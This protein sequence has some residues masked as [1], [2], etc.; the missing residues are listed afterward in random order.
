MHRF[1]LLGLTTFAAYATIIALGTGCESPECSMGQVEACP[2]GTRICLACRVGDDPYCAD[3]V[4]HYG[5]PMWTECGPIRPVRP[6]LDPRWRCGAASWGDG[7]AC[8]CGCGAP[9]PDCKGT[10]ADFCSRCFLNGSCSCPKLDGCAFTDCPGLI[11]P[12]DNSVCKKPSPENTDSACANG[13]DDDRDGVVDCADSD[14]QG[15]DACAPTTWHCDPSLYADGWRCDCGCGV[16]DPD[17]KDATLDS[18][19][20][21]DQFGGCNLATCPGNIDPTD[22]ASCNPG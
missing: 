16:H 8:D 18:C 4:N 22:N 7:G 3:P 11:D 12:L 5:A 14:C 19:T 9:D 10:T 20:V 13:L 6:P 17:C 15:H 2:G 1:L 21:C